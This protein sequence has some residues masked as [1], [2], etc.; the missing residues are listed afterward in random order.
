VKI[1][2]AEDDMN[3]IKIAKMVLERVGGHE[4]ETAV[5]GGEA[6]TKALAN[7]Y[8]LIILDGMMP[9]RPGVEVCRLYHEQ[10]Q[11]Q[12][13]NIIFLS[14]KSSQEDIKE[15]LHIGTGYIQKPFEPQKLCALI[16]DILS[17]KAAA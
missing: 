3:I 13:A 1:L 14:A 12:Q 11:G 6:L 7:D 8:D 5:D 2:I 9:V 4:V 17:K 10:K 15:F 16:D